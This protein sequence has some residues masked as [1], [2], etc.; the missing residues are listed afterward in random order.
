[1]KV[2]VIG[3]VVLSLKIDVPRKEEQARALQLRQ[4]LAVRDVLPEYDPCAPAPV[5]GSA[6]PILSLT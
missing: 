2:S 5:L 3:G 6:D 1:M 4:H